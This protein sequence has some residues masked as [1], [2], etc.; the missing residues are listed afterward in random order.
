MDDARQ[1]EGHK[2]GCLVRNDRHSGGLSAA[3]RCWPELPA[4][5]RL[6]R[7]SGDTFRLEVE[8]AGGGWCMPRSV[9]RL[10][11]KLRCLDAPSG[12]NLRTRAAPYE[13]LKMKILKCPFN[14]GFLREGTKTVC[15]RPDVVA[16]ILRPSIE[17]HFART[18]QHLNVT[19]RVTE[20]AG[21][22]WW[23]QSALG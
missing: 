15:I 22:S 3:A 1:N 17:A 12:L 9:R 6:Y 16:Y 11:S 13:E 10:P 14:A 20:G 21:A 5:F 19:E 2:Y 23:P 4:N 18:Q 8:S 7:I